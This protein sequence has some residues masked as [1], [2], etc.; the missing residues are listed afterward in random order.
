MVMRNPA[1]PVVAVIG[2]AKVSD[3]INV[4]ASIFTFANTVIIGGAMAY[5]FLEA[6]GCTMGLSKVER[7]AMEKGR[8]VDLLSTAR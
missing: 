7:V 3:K 2:G 4:L 8:E 6:N 5:T 1:Q